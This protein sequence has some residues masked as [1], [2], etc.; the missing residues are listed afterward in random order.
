MSERSKQIGIYTRQHISLYFREKGWKNILFAAGI[1]LLVRLFA[2]NNAFVQD[3]ATKMVGLTLSCI[4]IWN[5]IFNSIQTICKERAIVKKEHRAGLHIS[6]YFI[7][8]MIFQLL[9]CAVQALAV[10]LVVCGGLQTETGGAFYFEMFITFFLTTYA[11]D[12]LG[13]AISA[14]VHKPNTAM[15]VMPFILIVQLMF[16]GVLFS[17]NPA[18][19]R[20]TISKSS[21]DSICI[22]ADYN[23]LDKK[24]DKMIA[25]YIRG[26][27]SNA[28]EYNISSYQ[29][30]TFAELAESGELNDEDDR[31]ESLEHTTENL[32]LNWGLL[33]AH[34]AVY[35]V[36]GIMFLKLID[37][38]KR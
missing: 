15:V 26:M 31:D 24:Q 9:V 17:I 30:E 16:C 35:A 27:K 6:S 36:V 14:I 22:S 23:E 2:M 13:L 38:D 3:S 34:T 7:S 29:I 1:A 19:T 32:M 8:H 12:V 25:D 5:G 21:L 28:D 20:I 4:C 37:R 10:L 11:A 33:I 18:A